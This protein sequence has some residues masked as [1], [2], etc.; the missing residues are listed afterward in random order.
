MLL[1][2]VSTLLL[3]MFFPGDE[4]GSDLELVAEKERK[5]IGATLWI[6]V[7]AWSRRSHHS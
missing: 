1:Q 5:V 7:S 3:Q 2:V 6:R 4:G